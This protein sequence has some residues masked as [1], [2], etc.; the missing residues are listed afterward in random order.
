MQFRTGAALWE[1]FT[2]PGDSSQR[3]YRSPRGTGVP[4]SPI[5]GAPDFNDPQQY[6]ELRNPNSFIVDL[7]GRYNLGDALRIKQR[8]EV[9]LLVVNA[10]G[11]GDT[12][13]FFDTYAKTNNRFGLASSRQSPLQAEVLLRFRN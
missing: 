10:L 12:T 3:I 9:V 6:T 2:N 13:N 8:L 5:S 11:A 7:Q 1:N 4:V